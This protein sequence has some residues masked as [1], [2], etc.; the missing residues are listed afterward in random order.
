[1]DY[2]NFT[3]GAEIHHEEGRPSLPPR[4][5]VPHYHGDEVRVLFVVGAVVII[6]AKSIGADLPMTTLEAVIAAALLVVA[7]GITNPEP[8]V[9]WI[10]WL[11]ALLAIG[12]TVLF[13]T[14]VITHYQ[15]GIDI[16]SRSFIFTEALAILSLAALY[17]TTRTIRGFLQKPTLE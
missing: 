10:H 8:K 1:M 16:F 3:P 12:G 15:T 9:A 13:G 6:I 7:A 2:T 14:T 4:R 17:F 5:R 11:N